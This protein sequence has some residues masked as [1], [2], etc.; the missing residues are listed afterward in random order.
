MSNNLARFVENAT[1]KFFKIHLVWKW[2]LRLIRKKVKK[3]LKKRL[4]FVLVVLLQL[5][6]HIMIHNSN[7]DFCGQVISHY[8]S[9]P[10][11]LKEVHGNLNGFFVIDRAQVF[12]FCAI[13]DLSQIITSPIVETEASWSFLNCKFLYYCSDGTIL[14]PSII[15]LKR[16]R[17]R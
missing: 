13:I 11:V 3:W 10:L 5:W 15:I 2:S 9:S 4:P 17:R 12:F 8:N 7:Y 14:G 6:L 16:R 1:A